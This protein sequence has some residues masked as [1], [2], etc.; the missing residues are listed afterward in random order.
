M[1]SRPN[2]QSHSSTKIHILQ[3]KLDAD[4]I[5]ELYSLIDSSTT[6]DESGA[7]VHL[8]L[9]ADSSDADVIVTNIRMRKRFERHLDW[10]IAVD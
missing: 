10:N 7:V 2:N 5:T 9:S 6:P 4:T 3:A 8:E 1:F